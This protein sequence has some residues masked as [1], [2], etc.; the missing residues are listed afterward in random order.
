MGAIARDN[1][2]SCGRCATDRVGRGAKDADAL[3]IT[4]RDRAR[5]VGA[6]EVSLNDIA[7]EGPDGNSS[8]FETID[9][10][11]AYRA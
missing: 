6:E 2:S 11:P 9:H 4:E 3:L 5:R 1:V 7:R 8:Q 10:Q